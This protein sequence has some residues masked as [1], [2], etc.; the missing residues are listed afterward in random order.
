M[1]KLLKLYV[2]YVVCIATEKEF[3]ENEWAGNM[4]VINHKGIKGQKASK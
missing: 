3:V 4:K 1:V 2:K